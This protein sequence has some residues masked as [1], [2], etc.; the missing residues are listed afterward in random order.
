MRI[1]EV[2]AHYSMNTSFTICSDWVQI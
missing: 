1:I 2:L